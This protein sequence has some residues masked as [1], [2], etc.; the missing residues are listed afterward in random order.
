MIDAD[1]LLDFLRDE[2]EERKS[3][4]KAADPPTIKVADL[5]Y[6]EALETVAVYVERV[7]EKAA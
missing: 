1:R 3:A 4:M 6:L 5:A 7:T 2:A